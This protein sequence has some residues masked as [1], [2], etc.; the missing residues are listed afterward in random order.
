MRHA[1]A[2]L[3][4]LATSSSAMAAEICPVTEKELIGAWKWD[5]RYE[6]GPFEEFLLG[7][8]DGEQI[9]NSW[10]HQTPDISNATW[11][12]ENCRLV[13]TPKAS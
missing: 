3:F 8:E 13:V 1:F 11:G 9:F 6:G 12:L 5:D 7:S 2:L 10:L 4:L